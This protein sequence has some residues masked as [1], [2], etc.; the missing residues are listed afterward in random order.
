MTLTVTGVISYGHWKVNVYSLA[1]MW[2][3]TVTV[4]CVF[5][6]FCL[7]PFP[8]PDFCLSHALDLCVSPDRRLGVGPFW[9]LCLW[10]WMGSGVMR[11]TAPPCC[12][13][14]LAS[15]SATFRPEDTQVLQRSFATAVDQTEQKGPLA[16]RSGTGA[17]TFKKGMLFWSQIYFF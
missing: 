9:S 15:R 11:T 8:C 13:G 5:S 7:F 1:L 16:S 6:S 17:G 2:I 14:L 4:F 3:S 10:L 12:D